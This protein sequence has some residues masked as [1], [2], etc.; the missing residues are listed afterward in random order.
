MIDLNVYLVLGF[1][2]AHRY[3]S[4]ILISLHP[5]RGEALVESG[6]ILERS[7]TPYVRT[8]I[9]G[10]DISQAIHTALWLENLTW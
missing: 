9:R 1:T 4:P 8:E 7:L 2:E 3:D 10:V 5:S 6:D